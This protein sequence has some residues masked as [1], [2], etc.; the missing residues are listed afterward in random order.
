MEVKVVMRSVLDGALG[1]ISDETLLKNV[2]EIVKREN[3]EE[4]TIKTA[5][6]VSH[7]IKEMRGE[8][9]LKADKKYD[10]NFNNIVAGL[11]GSTCYMKDNF[12]KLYKRTE[13]QILRIA[14]TVLVN[15][16][17]STFGHSHVTLQ[18]TN[19]PK[20]L[21]LVL[22]N[23]KEYNTSEKSARYT[24]MKDINPKNNALFDKWMEI[25]NRKIEQKYNSSLAPNFFDEKGTKIKKLSQE[26]AR[27]LIPI[28]TPT[29]MVYT[30]SFRQ[31]NYLCHLFEKEIEQPSNT[32]YKDLKTDMLDF[33]DNIKMLNLYIPELEDHKNRKLSLFGDGIADSIYSNVY[34]TEYPMSFACLAQAQRHRTLNYN[35]IE[36]E[37]NP[38]YARC[39]IPPIIDDD[40]KL[41]NEF[42]GD[43]V[44]VKDTIPQGT[45]VN[46]VER[47]TIE[48][49]VLKAKE[50]LCS[51]AQK[52]VR[53]RTFAT[54]KE[55][56]RALYSTKEKYEKMAKSEFV[57]SE[58]R[59]INKAK[60][61]LTEELIEKI[62]PLTKGSRCMSGYKCAS[63]C[64]FKE[65]I[66]LE[67]MV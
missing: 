8:D 13:D 12:E 37:Y 27:Y 41:K 3:P 29:N 54:A 64:G 55:Y 21:A 11:M 42:M 43:F 67:S 7:I 53:D 51:Q 1:Q 44:S 16:H 49:F 56:T 24:I 9:L 38:N 14:N 18:I 32:Y 34:Q 36:S 61:D 59:K 28:S 25:F 63:P 22:N 52:E 31:L 58:F 45:L 6:L 30:T 2:I 35:I 40:K 66:E 17:H 39:Y 4:D 57:K 50:R 19:I 62:E 60:M 33:I 46:C 5:N 48:N 20:S 15:G 26:N 23:E 10:N 47:G 65:G